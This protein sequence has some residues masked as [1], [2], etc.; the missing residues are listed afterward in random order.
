MIH[1]TVVQTIRG[2][3]IKR[4]V[5]AD[6]ICVRKLLVLARQ[7]IQQ[8]IVFSP[9]SYAGDNQALTILSKWIG[10]KIHMPVMIFSNGL[11]NLISAFNIVPENWITLKYVSYCHNSPALFFVLGSVFVWQLL[12]Q[13][14]CFVLAGCKSIFPPENLYEVAHVIIAKLV[15]NSLDHRV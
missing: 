2:S 5:R 4:P 6:A 9:I 3:V 7:I 10:S 14:V 13:E 15:C 1:V 11:Y 8:I 12:Q